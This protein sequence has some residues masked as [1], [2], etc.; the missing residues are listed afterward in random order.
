MQVFSR[1]QTEQAHVKRR[2]KRG[3]RMESY[4]SASSCSDLVFNVG[5]RRKCA[6]FSEVEHVYRRWG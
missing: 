2:M 4:T 6:V 5:W 3:S 1:N